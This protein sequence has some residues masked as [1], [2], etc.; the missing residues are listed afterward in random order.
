MDAIMIMIISWRVCIESSNFY[1]I[2]QRTKQSITSLLILAAST[3]L[4]NPST[5]IVR[6]SI[7]FFA[8][9]VLCFIFT[10][11]AIHTFDVFFTLFISHTDKVPQLTDVTI[12]IFIKHFLFNWF[13]FFINIHWTIDC[14]FHIDFWKYFCAW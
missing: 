4:I 11:D 2:N 8:F 7:F 6:I 5:F 10:D 12:K 14:S 9:V 1:P 13:E 3:F